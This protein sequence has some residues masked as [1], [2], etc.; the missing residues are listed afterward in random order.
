M[1]LNKKDKLNEICACSYLA[2]RS[3]DVRRGWI[4][5]A[6]QDRVCVT[7]QAAYR[8]AKLN[9]LLLV[10]HSQADSQ[11]LVDTSSLGLQESLY[12]CV[13]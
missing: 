9:I 5:N 8:N 3:D 6:A 11:N 4:R 10:G 7:S 2:R 1:R 12:Y 13:P